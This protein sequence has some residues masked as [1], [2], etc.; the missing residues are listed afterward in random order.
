MQDIKH[1]IE[2]AIFY[3]ERAKDQADS[4][5]KMMIDIKLNELHIYFS[6]IKIQECFKSDNVA[7][8]KKEA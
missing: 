1:Y 6:S 3:L 5:D 8:L 7:K 4:L 2:L